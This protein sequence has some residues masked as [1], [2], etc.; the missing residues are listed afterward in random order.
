MKT[1]ITLMMACWVPVALASEIVTL[2]DGRE[3]QLNDDFTWQYVSPVEPSA[4][5][6]SRLQ[7]AT[8]ARE[9]VLAA[10]LIK[11]QRG[12]LVEPGNS[13]PTLQLNHS[14]LDIVLGSA[15]YQDGRLIVPTAITNQSTQSVIHITLKV[16]VLDEQGNL[17][18]T[19][20]CTIW[21]SIKRM[22]D[23]YLRP[24]GSV[25]GKAIEIKVDQAARYQI[26]A[27]VIEVE[28]R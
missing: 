27:S 9:P 13:K 15:L 3:V 20:N 1:L 16:D 2:K 5:P 24:Q 8:V 17:L 23:T 25:A 10:P 21:Q 19:Q 11:P 22:A 14:G 6:A 26:R 4:T 7:P 18:A 12:S 28:S